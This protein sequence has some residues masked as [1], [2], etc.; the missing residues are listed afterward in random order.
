MDSGAICEIGKTREEP[1]WGDQEFTFGHVEMLV[2]HLERR[3][4]RQN[5]KISVGNL[6]QVNILYLPYVLSN[7][8][9]WGNI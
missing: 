8:W 6:C 4:R 5:W 2:I 3:S 7:I 9:S 1:L